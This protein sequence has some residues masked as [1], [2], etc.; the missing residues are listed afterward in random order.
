MVLAPC[1]NRLEMAVA[2]CID[3]RGPVASATQ[4]EF[5]M[6]APRRRWFR[7][8]LPTLFVVATLLALWL[9]HERARAVRRAAL[10]QEI[11]FSGGEVSC[12]YQFGDPRYF[13]KRSPLLEWMSE[14]MGGRKSM[15]T[16]IISNAESAVRADSCRVSRI[17]NLGLRP[18]WQPPATSRRSRIR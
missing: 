4:D 17:H 12:R 5:P 6:T 15:T 9:G 18:I 1:V 16:V 13:K 7:F 8:S 3:R 11:E 14:K 10:A 2:H